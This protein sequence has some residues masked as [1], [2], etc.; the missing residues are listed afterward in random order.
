MQQKPGVRL[1]GTGILEKNESGQ[2]RLPFARHGTVIRIFRKESCMKTQCLVLLALGCLTLAA[3]SRK[4]G[5]STAA[6]FDAL[7][8]KPPMGWNSW[9]CFG[10]DVNEEQVRANAGFMAENLKQHGW[11][12]VVVDLGWYLPAEITIATFKKPRPPQ[13]MDEWGR[14]V[15]DTGKFPSSSR[16]RG[17]KPLADYCHAK[18]LK[19]GIHIMRG[20]PWQAVEQNTAVL[21]TEARAADLAEPADTCVWYDGMAGVDAAS[22]EGRAYYASLFHLYADWGVDYVKMDD[23]SQ[24]YHAADIEAVHDAIRASGRPMV[25]SLSPGAT[26]LEQAAHVSTYANLWRISPDFW[27]LWPFLRRQFDLCRAWQPHVKPGHWPDCDMLPLGRLRKTG[28]DDWVAGHMGRTPAEITDEPSRFT[29]DEK[30]TLMTLWCVFRSPLMFG[31]H[32]P[33]TDSLT[34]AL[35]MNGE[36][37]AVNQDSRNNREVRSENGLVVWAA[38]LPDSG[39]AVGLF[40]LNGEGPSDVRVTWAE[41]GLSGGGR[42]VRDIWA[43]REAGLFKGGFSAKIPAHGAGFFRIL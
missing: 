42:A 18:G 29:A 5:P 20:I 11:E 37:L 16:K 26:P 25:L 21:G 4:P 24:P 23:T 3:C 36:A 22:P 1:I 43:R 8:L 12:Y 40:N 35:V 15:P 28:P 6:D 9:N 39:V 30:T 38:D 13:A 27:D 7:A 33:E 19:F 34:L 41:L 2:G 17:F 10:S 32:L 31:G 14:L